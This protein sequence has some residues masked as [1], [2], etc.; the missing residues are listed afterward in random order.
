MDPQAP[1]ATPAAPVTGSGTL[2]ALQGQVNS[3]GPGM[4]TA[5]HDLSVYGLFMQADW[6]VKAVMIMLL[7]ASI[8]SWA[9]II[10]KSIRLRRLRNQAKQFEDAFWSGGS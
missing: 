9:I 2:D 1:S 5:A 4:G 8:W 7:L 10:D 6:I 3:T